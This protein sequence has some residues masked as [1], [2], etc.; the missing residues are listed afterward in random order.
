M[1]V[2]GDESCTAAVS[3]F[4][5]RLYSRLQS[6]P[7]TVLLQEVSIAMAT[8][9]GKE[10]TLRVGESNLVVVQG[11][12]GQPVLVLH[13]EL[14]DPG[15]LKWHTQ[16]AGSRTLMIPQHPGFRKSPQIRW[17]RNI[18]DLACFYSRFIQEQG[19][20]PIDVIGFSL[21]G[22]IAAEMA[23][24]NSRQF[25]HMILVGATGLKP[26][27]GEIAD[28]FTST[29]RNYLN[30][31]VYDQKATTEFAELYGGAH[32]PEQFE[33]WEDAR[34]ETSRIAWQPYMFNPSLPHLL[35]GVRDLPTLLIWGRQDRIVPLSAGE[36]YHKSVA[37]SELT[38]LDRCGH[39]PEIEKQAEFS[40]L[41]QKF[42]A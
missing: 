29:A 3:V 16:L 20:T 8:P 38:V 25:R 14:G 28:L 42:L 5:S 27:D 30:A 19:L 23:V 33:G 4:E 2:V 22:W 31:S 24:N 10:Q 12:S 34:A 21:G 32:S 13:E 17:I 6:A 11:G 40:Q 18:R 1:V 37:G 39:R 36:V 26:P 35:E 41:V 15:W 7:Q 9:E